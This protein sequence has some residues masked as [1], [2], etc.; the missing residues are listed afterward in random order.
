M[1]S[2]DHLQRLPPFERDI[3]RLHQ[4]LR[5]P[6]TEIARILGC[7]QPTVNYRYKRVR[8][9]LAFLEKLPS[10]TP[11]EIRQVLTT[12]GAREQDIEAMVLY[13]ETTSQSEVARRMNTSQGAV[14][15]WVLR[16]L[17][18]HLQKDMRED[19]LHKRVRTVCGMLTSKP[20]I[21]IFNEPQKPGD[22]AKHKKVHRR[23]PGPPKF[24]GAL[25]VGEPVQIL[26]GIY[27]ALQGEVV[28]ITETEM[29]VR[30]DLESQ[31]ITLSWAR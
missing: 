15:Y 31:E 25:A 30:L 23:L 10:V 29:R 28:E 5:K 19:D 20:G 3:L 12:L 1:P 7:S 18:D 13:V 24:S 21:G 11:D 26:D 16:V 8:D 22:T 17:T 27:G 2:D 9:R 14:R 4:E 6:Q